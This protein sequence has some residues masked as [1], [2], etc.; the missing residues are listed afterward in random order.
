MMLGGP[1]APGLLV[2]ERDGGLVVADPQGQIQRLGARAIERLRF[3]LRELV[4]SI[5]YCSY[6]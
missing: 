3:L 5:I 6:S 1:Q 4:D 2:G